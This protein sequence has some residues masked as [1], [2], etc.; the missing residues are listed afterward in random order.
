MG[1]PIIGCLLVVGAV[2]NRRCVRAIGARRRI[3][4]A[5]ARA[6]Y[7][8][9]VARRFSMSVHPLLKPLLHPS[10]VAVIGASRS[11]TSV[12]GE[13]FANLLRRPFVG[14]VYPVNPNAP[15]VQGVRAYGSMAHVPDTVDLAIVVVPAAQVP[16][17]IADCANAR[18]RAAVVVSAGFAEEGAKGA[19]TQEE[20]ISVAQAAGMRI[21]GPNCLGVLSTEPDVALHATFATGW[22]P[23]GNVSI[24]SQ[25]GAL[26]IA[27]LDEARDHGI[28]I[29]HFVS[30]GNEADVSA[31]ELVEYWGEDEGTRVI[32]LYLESFP[33]PRRFL[34]VARRVTRRKPVVVVKGGRSQSGARAAGSHTGA[35]ATRDVVVDAL[36]A[37][38]GVLRVASLEELFD[39]A[40][41]LASEHRPV[42]RR[43]AIVTN[44]GGP[45]I[46]AADA[47]EA[48]GLTVPA[49]ADA[50]A[51]DLRAALPHASVRNPVDLLAGASADAFDAAVSR[52]ARD[53]AID[54]LLVACVPTPS[55]DVVAVAEVLA[56]SRAREAKALVACVLGTKGIEDARSVLREAGIPVYGLPEAAAGALGASARYSATASRAEGTGVPMAEPR[57]REAAARVA[58]LAASRLPGDGV[59]RGRWLPGGEATALLEAFG[60]RSVAGA[61]ARDAD[62][63]ARA[64]VSLGFP[65]AL[66]VVSRAVVH[67]SDIGGVLLDLRD[68]EA[69]RQGVATLERRM[70]AA[71][72]RGDPDHLLVQAMVP[73]GVELFLGMS[74][75]PVFG[76]VIAFGIGGVQL[77]LWNDVKMRLAPLT[78]EDA[79][80]MLDGIR[81]RPLLDGF[82]GGPPADRAA[83]VD[84]IL[85]ISRLS[86]DVPDVSELDVNPLVALE[87]GRGVVAVDVRVRVGG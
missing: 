13:I 58:A 59:G 15:S 44:A 43:V 66:K 37:Q 70:V 61:V 60:L 46:L 33:N 25:S 45:G 67:K 18:V 39:A 3:D 72:H 52:I 40:T 24:A 4:C 20:I 36:L 81:G 73:R 19:R 29:R 26:G 16:R 87:P 85:Q 49:F 86:M 35:L 65:V 34:D 30:L 57:A 10:S 22:P 11:R 54:V 69:V 79:G 12:G 38:A 2:A 8:V 17:A 68:E 42:G 1:P 41:L 14:P 56:R 64:A 80:A 84:A 7:G 53:P 21:V 77:E 63:A 32:L 48:Q 28:G 23:A 78:T 82:R 62:E 55:T 6:A 75:D 71:G 74:R 5:S 31:E 51:A 76:P 50:V 47:C 27:L 9:L 83:L